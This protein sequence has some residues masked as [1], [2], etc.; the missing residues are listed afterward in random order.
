VQAHFLC[1]MGASDSKGS[2]EPKKKTRALVQHR[3][4]VIDA[5]EVISKQGHIA[6]AA[7]F[8]MERPLESD[9]VVD[10]KVVGSGCSGPVQL[11]R[12]IKGDKL[13]AVKSFK[14]KSMPD[15]KIAELKNEVEIYLS[16]D[17]PHIARLQD[18]YETPEDLHL[19]MEFMA[20]GELYDRLHS[21]K[22][23]TELLAAETSRQML[24]A[25]GYLHAHGVAHRDLKLENFL[26]ESQ[27]TEHLKLIDFGFAKFWDGRSRME[28]AC[29]SLHYVAPE[30]L[31][32]SYTELCDCWSLGVIVF[33]LLTGSP[34]FHGSDDVVLGKI[35]AG[36]IHFNSRWEKLSD[37]GKDFVKGLLVVDVKQR[38]TAA[39]ALEHPWIT[40]A[41]RG[42]VVIDKE[43]ITSIRAYAH[44]SRFRRAC[45]SMMAWSLSMEDRMHLRDQF[46]ALDKDNNG[47]ITLNELKDV[48]E[49]D[50]H[51]DSFEAEKLFS[52][53]DA[54]NDGEICYSE[55][56]A[57][58]LQ[59]RCRLHE[60][61]LR[62]AF[63]RF[64][65]DGDGHITL[66]NLRAVIG[67]SFDGHDVAQLM[68]EAD[69][70]GDGRISYEEFFE[71]LHAEEEVQEEVPES[72]STGSPVSAV[73]S[74][75]R[76]RQ[77]Q[78]AAGILIDRGI[79]IETEQASTDPFSPKS[80]CG[81]TCRTPIHGRCGAAPPLLRK[82]SPS[83]RFQVM[84]APGGSFKLG[85]DE[86]PAKG[87][88]GTGV[89]P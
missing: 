63:K 36:K 20:G 82:G 77:A 66:D 79:S 44:A 11:A 57:A 69:T 25:L 29:G 41:D 62:N 67:D 80:S 6:V 32:K 48:L 27:D 55:F 2:A 59:D 18:V 15:R 9:Y 4:S 35:K 43:V 85:D 21:K 7:R 88:C 68:V 87:T 42:E 34:P 73:A 26:Y 74:P 60:D 49:K 53:I 54:N 10:P 8:H 65:V 1:G 24:L 83:G 70:K 72:P 17:H 86:S 39:K 38:M 33:M 28:Q 40:A 37:S 58:A 51:V 50:F 47:T 81:T 56:L 16:L 5:Q 84:A 78:E 52:S 71:Y 31:A 76:R 45:L 89:V 30:V 14:L 61:I 64:D 23:Y 12:S 19:V 46:T 13:Y 22:T 3:T 75:C